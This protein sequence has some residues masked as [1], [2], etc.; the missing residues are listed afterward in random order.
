V[1]DDSN[2]GSARRTPKLREAARVR[3]RVRV[4]FNILVELHSALQQVAMGE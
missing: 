4:T 2:P 1:S 3:V